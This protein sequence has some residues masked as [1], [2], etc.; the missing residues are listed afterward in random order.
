[1]QQENRGAG[2]DIDHREVFVR[3]VDDC[4]DE[5]QVHAGY[6]ENPLR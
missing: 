1:M 5:V 2:S 3:E 6:F 4:G